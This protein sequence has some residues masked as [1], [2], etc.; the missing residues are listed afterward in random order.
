MTRTELLRSAVDRLMAGGGR[1]LRRGVA[2]ALGRD[3]A[4]VGILVEP[5]SDVPPKYREGEGGPAWDRAWYSMTAGANTPVDRPVRELDASERRLVAFCLRNEIPVDGVQ[6]GPNRWEVW[7]VADPVGLR[8]ARRLCADPGLLERERRA[9]VAEK[10]PGMQRYGTRPVARRKPRTETAAKR[11]PVGRK[12]AGS[13]TAERR[14]GSKRNAG[15]AR[16]YRPVPEGGHPGP[17]EPWLYDPNERDRKTRK[18][19]ELQNRLAAELGRRGAEVFDRVDGVEVDLAFR[20]RGQRYVVEVKTL[21]DR[22]EAQQLRL[23]LGQVL[24]YRHA[25]RRARGWGDVAAVLYVERQPRDDRWQTLLGQL[26]VALCWP[27][28]LPRWLDSIAR[29]RP[30][31]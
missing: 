26:D 23:G 31:V 17:K 14:R 30:T 10:R 11:K 1:R 12:A 28:E 27:R 13:G 8:E 16:P 21:S 15:A 4:T 18:H 7:V 19:R 9:Y 24:D 3:P 29:A 22:N 6:V 25:V 20:L 5:S 2:D